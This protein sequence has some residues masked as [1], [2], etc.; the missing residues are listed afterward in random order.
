MLMHVLSSF[1][2]LIYLITYRWY[3]VVYQLAVFISRTSIRFV[4]I[5]FLPIF[6]ALQLLNV[7]IALTEIFFGYMNSIWIIIALIFWE[8]LLGGGCY[9]NAFNKLS[10]EIPKKNREMSI[11]IASIA[12][13]IG[14]ALAGF[15]AI[16]VHNAICNYGDR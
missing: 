4:H 8:G 2:C 9:V 7:A 3:N 1:S 12:D 11:A 14:I 10:I 15:T 5:N 16:P 6:P 13:S